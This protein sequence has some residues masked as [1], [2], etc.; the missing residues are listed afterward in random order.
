MATN[1]TGL[2]NH[3]RALLPGRADLVAMRRQPRRDLLAGVTVAIVALPL[4]LGFG[5][6]SGMG[7]EAGLITAIVAGA[8]AAIFGG[9]NLQVSGPTGAMTVVLVPVVARFGPSGVLMVGLFA[10]VLLVALAFARAGQYV[11]YVPTP[12]VE[13]FTVGIAAVIGLQQIPAA[14]GV[15][16]PE[17]ENVVAVAWRAAGEAVHAP[18]WAA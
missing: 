7:A 2:L 10:G 15:A 4:A 13:G 12:V 1:G 3:A 18:Q 17:G 5:V 9:S 14:L 6:T 11:K 16:K 8:L